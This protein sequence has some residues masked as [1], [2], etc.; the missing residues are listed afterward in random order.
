MK[1]PKV[2]V[3]RKMSA[4]EYYYNGNH[5]HKEFHDGKRD[6]DNNNLEIERI[7][8]RERCEYDIITR[9]EMAGW[10]T[11]K[12]DMIFS[13][14]GDS[15]AVATASFNFDRPQLNLRNDSR[16]AGVLCQHNLEEAIMRTLAGDY[17]IE[18]WTRQ[19]VFRDLEW[20]GRSLN[21]IV[22]GG[23]DLK[24]TKY[25]KFVLTTKYGGETT[26]KTMKT[27]Y[28]TIVSGTGSTG[29]PEDFTP[30]SRD[31][32][33]FKVRSASHLCEEMNADYVHIK[34]LGHQGKFSLDCADELEYDLPFN[35]VLEV[36]VSDAPLK[37]IIPNSGEK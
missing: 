28:L 2:L 17:K 11:Q 8:K 22:L 30:F 9:K 10:L 16:S 1:K 26:E 19:D 3:V 34:F 29:W 25:P 32:K 15:T 5:T 23:K 36:K 13:A 12:Y 18:E 37:V 20:V 27:T 4:L 6:Q 7:L 35:S 31:S 21:E 14:G 33:Y 24:V